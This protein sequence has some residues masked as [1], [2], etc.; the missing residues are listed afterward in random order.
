MFSGQVWF[1]FQH[2][3]FRKNILHATWSIFFGFPF[4]KMGVP[5]CNFLHHPSPWHQLW[6]FIHLRAIAKKSVEAIDSDCQWIGFLGKIL[7]GNPWWIYHQI[8][9]GF[10]LEFSHHPILWDWCWS[11]KTDRSM[12]LGPIY[13]R[14]HASS[15][16]SILIG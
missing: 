9:R 16:C 8:Y 11:W 15:K 6:T 12:P 5:W 7:T 1:I 4:W 3:F 14:N 2:P 10:R 13:R